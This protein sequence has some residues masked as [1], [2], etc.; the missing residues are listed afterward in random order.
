MNKAVSYMRDSN[1]KPTEG[2]WDHSTAS[3]NIES[4][5]KD[6]SEEVDLSVHQLM[7]IFLEAHHS[8][9]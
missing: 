3:K 8:Y 6:N 7:M 5:V 2:G 4:W 1:N 9:A